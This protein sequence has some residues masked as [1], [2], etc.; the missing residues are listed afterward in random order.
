MSDR[1]AYDAIFEPPAPVLPL[2]VTN[3]RS[4]LSVLVTALVDTGADATVIP[5][6][7]AEDLG[8]PI[9]DYVAI[10]GVGGRE[11]EAAVHAAL[12]RMGGTE[13]AVELVAFED[14]RVIGRDLLGRF[15]IRLDGPRRLLSF[16]TMPAPTR[17]AGRRP[18]GK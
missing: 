7:I 1:I 3:P 17:R 11:H 18:R 2:H 4:R 6:S 13:I 15:V 10:S 8:L 5:E 12:V 14:E 9:V 16:E